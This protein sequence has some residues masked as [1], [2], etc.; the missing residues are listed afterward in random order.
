MTQHV[1]AT[2]LR[3]DLRCPLG[4]GHRL[5]RSSGG[6]QR[7]GDHQLRIAD[8]HPI[9]TRLDQFDG[10]TAG[11]D[12]I[13]QQTRVHHHLGPID[14][15]VRN[16]S[17]RVPGPFEE[18][19]CSLEHAER[20]GQATSPTAQYGEVG[21][22][23]RLRCGHPEGFGDLLGDLEIGLGLAQ[24]PLLEEHQSPVLMDAKPV[25]SLTTLMEQPLADIEFGERLVQPSGV[26]EHVADLQTEPAEIDPGRLRRQLLEALERLAQE[27]GLG[28]NDG[29]R[30]GDGGAD[31]ERSRAGNLECRSSGCERFVKTAQ[32]VER[33]RRCT[34][35]KRPPD[36]AGRRV[37]ERG[38]HL[39]QRLAGTTLYEP[40]PVADVG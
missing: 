27:S 4:S 7:A 15:G 37:G 33:P 10:G 14:L 13:E 19:T 20:L 9:A 31:L 38:P 32:L 30:H 40:V 23:L 35:R 28:E 18:V 21:H 17:G 3:K 5:P 36:V 1:A 8:E 25:A 39:R 16:R 2:R 22:A 6:E 26:M 12:G 29:G 34:V 24:P 11:L